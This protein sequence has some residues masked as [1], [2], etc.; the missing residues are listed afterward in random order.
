MQT[1]IDALSAVPDF[2]AGV[3]SSLAAYLMGGIIMALV[4]IWEH[5]YGKP[6]P[7]KVCKWGIVAFLFISI[8]SAWLEQRNAFRDASSIANS[9]KTELEKEQKKVEIRDVQITALQNQVQSQQK[10]INESLVQLGKAQQQEPLK[11]TPYFMRSIEGCYI[12][13]IA[14]Y[15]GNYLVLTNKTITPIRLLVSCDKEI[16]QV[17]GSILGAGAHTGGGWGGRV[18]NNKTDFGVGILSPAWTTTNPL[19]VTVYT[20]EKSLNCSFSQR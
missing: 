14:K 1:L 17:T 12:G 11:L 6:T 10:T 7:W 19:I 3:V 2:V 15:H 4:W 9:R 20:N 18:T 8:F 13:G 16:A 5:K